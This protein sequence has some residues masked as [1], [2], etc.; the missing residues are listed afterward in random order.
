MRTKT[1]H[2]WGRDTPDKCPNRV[3]GVGW[4]DR[5]TGGRASGMDAKEREWKEMRR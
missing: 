1:M 2:G 5:D 3:L 4:G